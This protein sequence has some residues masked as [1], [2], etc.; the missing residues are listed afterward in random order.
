MIAVF[1]LTL[2]GPGY[3]WV[4]WSALLESGGIAAEGTWPFYVL[5]CVPATL[6]ILWGLF[7]DAHPIMGTRRD[8]HLLLG[9]S[10]WRLDGWGRWSHAVASP[11]GW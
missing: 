9:R 6:S 1:L 11:W 7:S 3:L 10:W 5:C 8:G 2:I 4:R